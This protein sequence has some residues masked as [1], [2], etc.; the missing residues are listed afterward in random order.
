MKLVNSQSL[1]IASLLGLLTFFD[2]FY[3]LVKAQLEPK[4]G[5]QATVDK[6]LQ[7][8]RAK[9]VNKVTFRIFKGTAN[10]YNTGNPT[11]RTDKLLIILDSPS[12]QSKVYLIEKILNSGTLLN[13]WS[14]KI[15]STC[16]NTAIV[17]FGVAKSDDN[18]DFYI[19]S[20][21]TTK[22]MKCGNP[23]SRSPETPPYSWGVSYCL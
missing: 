3:T 15:V 20:D 13:K 12:I 5:C 2:G 17:S 8:I 6:I 7:E 10:E 18:N 23:N 16:N 21:G 14:D 1:L 22:P 4:P 9:G 11:N 19:Q